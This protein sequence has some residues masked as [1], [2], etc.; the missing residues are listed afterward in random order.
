[1]FKSIKTRLAVL[2]LAAAVATSAH[3]GGN[4]TGAGASFV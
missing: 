4:V 2:A 1:M 3:A